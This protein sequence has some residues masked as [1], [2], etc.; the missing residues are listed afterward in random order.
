MPNPQV[1][2]LH[3]WT[4]DQQK[5]LAAA[6][7]LYPGSK[8]ELIS[9]RELRESGWKGQIGTL[10]KTRG[11][12]LIYYF[13]SESDIKHR[14][15]LVWTQ[16]LHRCSETVIAVEGKDAEVFGTSACIVGFPR[17]FLSGCL[18]V[19]TFTVAFFYLL[20][21][22]TIVKHSAPVQPRESSQERL[23]VAYI[24]PYP[25]SRSIAGG[26]VSHICGFLGG[27][28]QSAAS[29][30]I[31]SGAP[32]PCRDFEVEDVPIQRQRHIFWEATMLVYNLRFR[33]RVREL[34]GATV[35]R[36]IYQRHGRFV[37]GG[38]LLSRAFRVPLV[39]EYNGS[40]SWMSKFWDPGRFS[41]L[42]RLCEEISVRGA[43]KIV[44]VSD[45]LKQELVSAGIPEERVIVNPNG[46]DPSVFHPGCGGQQVRQELGFASSDIVA[47]FVGTFSY[48]HGIEVLE[49]AIRSLADQ[50]PQSSKR[51]RYLLIGDGPLKSDMA[52]RLRDLE[53]DGTVVFTGLVPHD[54]VRGYLDATDILLS[55]HIPMPDGRPFFGSP[56]KLFEY[57]AMGKAIVASNLDQLALVLTAERSAILVEPASVEQLAAGILRAA[58]DENLRRRLGEA[59]RKAAIERHTWKQNAARVLMQLGVPLREESLIASHQR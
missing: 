57:M 14:D 22:R 24:F 26:A 55:P 34:L 52:A 47:G 40:E 7:K 11:R 21:L 2:H 59:A 29:C 50:K 28:R 8:I 58:D 9:H 42:M 41:T 39:L 37:I 49:K 15:M 35:P 38:V 46:V 6:E 4:G 25:L 13:Q 30:R 18:D 1:I 17:F 16:L 54:K 5:A 36:L 27:V 10:R 53:S 56:T 12:A 3:V 23:D 51:I 33:D 31:F 43:S 19:L 48:W 20:A 32:L 44:V 45:V